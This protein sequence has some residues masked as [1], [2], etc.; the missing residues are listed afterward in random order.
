[1]SRNR[2]LVYAHGHRLPSHS[3]RAAAGRVLAQAG[4]PRWTGRGSASVSPY[5]QLAVWFALDCKGCPPRTHVRSAACHG[6]VTRRQ[7]SRAG[8]PLPDSDQRRL[9][10]DWLDVS[11]GCKRQRE[12]ETERR[13]DREKVCLFVCPSI[14]PSLGLWPCP[15]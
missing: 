14:S 5:W 10:A 11:A 6:L 15:S 1:E 7:R 9:F 4:G 2:G 13:R 8:P 3:A 12:S